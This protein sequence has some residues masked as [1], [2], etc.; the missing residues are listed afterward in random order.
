MSVTLG[1]ICVDMFDFCRP[2]NP[3]M[4]EQCLVAR[5]D[6]MFF[7]VYNTKHS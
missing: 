5:R 7:N 6:F 2:G 1:V 4:A 3:L